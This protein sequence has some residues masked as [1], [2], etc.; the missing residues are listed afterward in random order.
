MG[1]PCPC[2]LLPTEG[3]G[4]LILLPPLCAHSTQDWALPVLIWKRVGC[5]HRPDWGVASSGQDPL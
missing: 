5:F 2:S 1:S 4:V 3:P